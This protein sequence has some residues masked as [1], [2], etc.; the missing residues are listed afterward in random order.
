M[1]RLQC[2]LRVPLSVPRPVWGKVNVAGLSRSLCTTQAHPLDSL[3]ALHI[4]RH[5]LRLA[6]KYPS[7]K[8]DKVI[9]EIQYEFRS[10]MHEKDIDEIRKQKE[11]AMTGIS[12]LRKYTGFENS[13]N[14]WIVDLETD[15]MPMPPRP[16]PERK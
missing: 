15:P 7:I 4:Y 10:N 5:L 13:S 12:H 11:V 16:P 1:M 8:R 2:L 9:D 14:D 6:I 3:S